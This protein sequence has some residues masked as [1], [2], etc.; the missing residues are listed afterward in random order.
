[1]NRYTWER[2]YAQLIKE[3]EDH[4]QKEEIIEYMY[5]QLAEDTEVVYAN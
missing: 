4:P 1:M 3:L 2:R 5:Q